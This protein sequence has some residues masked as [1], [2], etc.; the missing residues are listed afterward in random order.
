MLILLVEDHKPLA[1]TVGTYLEA[2]GH[3]M[4]Y[5]ADGLS[6]MHM[7]VTGEFDVVI[8]DLMLPGVNGIDVCRRLRQDAD[9]T[10][11]IIMLTARDA[12]C[13]KLSGFEAGA[14]DYLI[15]PFDMAELEARIKALARRSQGMT[16][17][18]EVGP[19]IL[20]TGTLEASRGGEPLALSRTT[21][22]IL[23]LL[24]LKHPRVVSRR[25]LEREVWGDEPPESDALRSHLY[26]L[27]R[28]VD[29]PF[30]D[31]MIETVTGSGYRLRVPGR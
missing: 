30:A 29:R 9:F 15:K 26:N 12:L 28:A 25:L 20:D 11:P 7:A 21:F 27:R 18:L 8:L 13:D 4:D 31:C 14:D 22:A 3:T 1:E 10:A 5:A 23:R 6:A 24:M 16:S 17:R 19:L 2:C